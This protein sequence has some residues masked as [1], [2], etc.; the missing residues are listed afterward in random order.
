MV[1]GDGLPSVGRR[2]LGVTSERDQGESVR[3]QCGICGRTAYAGREPP[4]G[5]V[6]PDG[7]SL[8]GSLDTD[9]VKATVRG[10]CSRSCEACADLRLSGR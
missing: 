4:E 1:L 9:K 5:W 8:P 6:I 3:Y 7:A 10:Y 2:L